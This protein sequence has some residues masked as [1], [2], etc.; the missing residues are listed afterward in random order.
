[1][2]TVPEL[3]A[4]LEKATTALDLGPV[5]FAMIMSESASAY[6]ALLQVAPEDIARHRASIEATLHNGAG[7]ARVYAALVLRRIDAASSDAHLERLLASNEPCTFTPGGCMSFG[8]T[9]SDAAFRLL[10]D[11][12]T[13]TVLELREELKPFRYATHYAEPAI[14][15]QN[16]WGRRFAE[17]LQR[18]DLRLA[19]GVIGS[20]ATEGPPLGLFGAVL[21]SRVDRTRAEIC[22]LKLSESSARVPIVG[23]PTEH[24]T[25]RAVADIA[26]EW[27]ARLGFHPPT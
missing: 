13:P 24:T 8:G 2:A 16:A 21:L 22:L 1:M 9:V 6:C 25:D 4:V 5:G 7:A 17:L 26:R 11:R 27:L 10:E 19:S 23:S 15:A 12:D 20:F 3:F 18:D 14:D